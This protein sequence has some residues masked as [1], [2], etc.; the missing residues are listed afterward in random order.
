M[1]EN[2]TVGATKI[3]DAV[4][5]DGENATGNEIPDPG[6]TA[7]V[8]D[9]PGVLGAQATEAQ[10]ATV[11]GVAAGAANLQATSSTG[12]IAG[13]LDANGSFVA[14]P[15]PFLVAA[16]AIIRSGILRVRAAVS[17]SLR[18]G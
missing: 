4:W 10:A 14:G 1:T 5:F 7:F 18:R 3:Y 11:T 12:V 8:S 13:S 15:L 9:N 17:A 2:I 6:Q 16:T